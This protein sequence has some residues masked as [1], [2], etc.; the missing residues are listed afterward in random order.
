LTIAGAGGAQQ[1]GFVS[2][3]TTLHEPVLAIV[4]K[5]ISAEKWPK[6]GQ[7]VSR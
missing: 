2:H 3:E 7:I 4:R 1:N 6:T 5:E